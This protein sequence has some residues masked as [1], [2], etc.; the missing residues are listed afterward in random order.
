LRSKTSFLYRLLTS[1]FRMMPDFFIAGEAKCGTT[2]LYRYLTMHPCVYSADVKEPGSFIVHGVSPLLCRMHYP[3]AWRKMPAG[4]I[5]KQCRAG[6]ATANYLASEDVAKRIALLIPNARIIVMMRNPVVRC[7]SDYQMMKAVGWETQDFDEGVERHLE[8]I[9]DPKVEPLVKWAKTTG[10]GFIRFILRG[11][12]VDNIAT[13]QKYLPKEHFLFVK[14]EEFFEQPQRVLDGVFQFLG[15]QA[16]KINSFPVL[17]KGAYQTGM[18]RQTI[19]R[20]AE[21]YQPHNERLY[22]LIG[23]DMGWD[24]GNIMDAATSE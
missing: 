9:R 3:F 14:S 22:Q 2:S 16:F 20:L 13:W 15:V 18:S 17:R 7:F 4:I 6:E 23:R 12:Y 21:F 11:V 24:A 5:G 1:P 10:E 19:Q 8:W